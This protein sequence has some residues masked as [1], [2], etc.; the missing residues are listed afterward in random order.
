MK[1]FRL[2]V[3]VTYICA[4]S[5]LGCGGGGGESSPEACQAFKIFN[6]EQCVSD[7]L[8]VV[9]LITDGSTGCTGT[10]VANDYVLTAAHCIVG[11]SFWEAVHDRGSQRGFS[12]VYNAGFLRLGG[13]FDIGIIR[14]DGIASN[15]G[16]TPAKFGLGRATQVGD[17]LKV[18]GYGQDGTDALVD[19]DPRAVSLIVQGFIDNM[20]ATLFDAEERGTCRGDSGGA[21]TYDGRIVA[22]VQG[23]GN[24]CS[25]GNINFFVDLRLHG[26]Y[27]FLQN[28]LP[29]VP[30]E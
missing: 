2:F 23:G 20:I 27:A 6:G 13:A 8:P 3:S 30:L 22:T 12:A 16:V 29:G 9:Q 21:A 15:F 14:F 26:N 17:R 25:S 4:I 28:F 10:I 24:D 19:G 11:G 1:C 18:I 7:S 5:F